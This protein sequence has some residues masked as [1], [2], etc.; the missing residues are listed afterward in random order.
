MRIAKLNFGEL[1][2]ATS[3]SASRPVPGNWVLVYGSRYAR[4]KADDHV[5]VAFIATG[6]EAW[7][8]YEGTRTPL[9]SYNYWRRIKTD[10]NDSQGIDAEARQLI[11]ESKLE[12]VPQEVA[13]QLDHPGKTE[14]Q[15]NG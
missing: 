14:R 12:P 7:V 3:T 2:M 1:R 9:S 15:N 5:T 13:N 6:G 10:A 11:E 4:R 8:D